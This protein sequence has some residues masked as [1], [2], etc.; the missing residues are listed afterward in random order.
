MVKKK[1]ISSDE[2]SESLRVVVPPVDPQV[3]EKSPDLIYHDW[4]KRYLSD[5]QVEKHRTVVYWRGSFWLW[6]KKHPAYRRVEP[7]EMEIIILRWL[8][9]KELS[10]NFRVAEFVTRS[11][12]AETLILE[13][14]LPDMGVWLYGINRSG[15]YLSMTNGLVSPIAMSRGEYGMSVHNPAWFSGVLVPYDYDGEAECLLWEHTISYL[16]RGDE[17][18]IALLQEFMGY[19]LTRDISRQVVLFLVGMEGTGKSTVL[20]VFN[21]LLGD[22]NISPTKLSDF[23][24]RFGPSTTLGKLLNISD[25][26]DELPK[27]AEGVFNW[28]VG[29]RMMPFEEK[30]KMPVG[31]RPTA[32]LLVAMN[33]WPKM[34]GKSG[35][36]Y[37]RIKAIPFNRH[38]PE[39]ERDIHLWEKLAAERAGIFN[40]AIVG[41][42]RLLT[43]GWTEA[44]SSTRLMEEV[45]GENQPHVRF[46]SEALVSAS[47]SYII[48]KEVDRLYERWCKKHKCERV[49]PKILSWGIRSMF[50]RAVSMR[51]SVGG[52]QKWIWLNIRIKEN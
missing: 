35:A 17:E 36:V 27:S 48:S 20:E 31:A 13:S 51:R 25:E 10:S 6:S 34:S 45:R 23:G 5:C 28:F 2:S 52:E 33:E 40:W 19:C 29:G 39:K 16:L 12:M 32:K 49:S 18:C 50:P 26:T 43:H 14:E 21:Q 37:R 1:L 41:L 38:L 30:F 11:L 24:S 42:R 7:R 9:K 44:R 3:K 8:Q 22:K 4:A 15:D 47:G 46:L